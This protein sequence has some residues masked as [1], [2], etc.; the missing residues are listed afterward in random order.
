V[1]DLE[2]W[3]VVAAVDYLKHTLPDERIG[4]IAVSMGAAAVVLA[5]RPLALNAVVLE[6]MYPTIEEALSDRMKDAFGAWGPTLT[7]L[8]V[9]QLRPRLGISPSR[10]HPI[11]NIAHIGA[12]V[13]LIH[14]AEDHLTTL[15]EAKRVFAA[16]AEP[17]TF[18]IVPGAGHVDMHYFAPAEYESRVSRFLAE[19]IVRDPAAA[20]AS[21]QVPGALPPA[22]IAGCHRSLPTLRAGGG[23]RPRLG[24]GARRF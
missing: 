3:D 24:A 2:S 12:P 19:H 5:K 16:A 20:A 13:L 7:Q 22:A 8:L 23:R 15:A 1:G 17:K 10:L 9:L 14:G 18:W 21:V 4:V 11:D 6:S